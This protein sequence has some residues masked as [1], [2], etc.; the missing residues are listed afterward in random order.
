MKERVRAITSRN[1]GR[2]LAQVVARAA[3]L[4]RRAGRRTSGS[5][6]RRRCSRSVD[7]MAS[8]PPAR[9]CI[10]NSGSGAE[11][12]IASCSAAEC[13]RRG[14]R[15][16]RLG[17]GRSWWRCGSPYGA[18]HRSARPRTSISS[19]SRAWLPLTSTHRTAGCGPACPVVWEGSRR[20]TLSYSLSRFRDRRFTV[21][22]RAAAVH[23]ALAPATR[24]LHR[25]PHRRR[26][27]NGQCR[28]ADPIR[29]SV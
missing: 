1:G 25:L 12:S 4:S 7:Q 23:V 29:P 10:S 20:V 16:W 24:R 13:L 27:E 6:T 26:G 9:C 14:A 21:R 22:R 28:V 19:E 2:S 15:R 3:Q 5:R 17:H 11:R 18:S 8:P